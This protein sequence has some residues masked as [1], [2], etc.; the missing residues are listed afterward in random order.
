MKSLELALE[1]K[2]MPKLI[3]ENKLLVE[4]NMYY[5]S[6]LSVVKWYLSVMEEG[7]DTREVVKEYAIL[8]KEHKL[9]KKESS[10]E[11][12]KLTKTNKKLTKRLDDAM[13]SLEK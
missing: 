10:A 5:E 7:V 12:K 4:K 2:A 9:L 6:E 1:K 13:K 8:K 11:I 3:L